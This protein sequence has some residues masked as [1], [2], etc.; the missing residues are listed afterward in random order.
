M[1]AAL[2]VPTA[3]RAFLDPPCSDG[4]RIDPGLGQTY[5][6]NDGTCPVSTPYRN[7]RK[8]W[9]RYNIGGTTYFKEIGNI[10]GTGCQIKQ[11]TESFLSPTCQ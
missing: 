1:L 10:Q 4:V 9:D 2:A 11:I 7:Y 6:K 3:S 8:A 5:T